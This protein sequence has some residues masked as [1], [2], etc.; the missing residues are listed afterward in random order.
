MK[1]IEQ[2]VAELDFFK[3][4][5]PEQ[6]ATV[7]G[8]GR[9]RAF[10]PGEYVLREGEEESHFY[11]IRNGSVTIEVFSPQQ[12]AL[13]VE[14][15][16][17]GDP[18]GWSWLFP[19]HHARFDARAIDVV[20]TIEFDGVCLRGK[21]DADHELGYTLLKLFGSVIAQRLHNTRM[22]LLDVYAPVAGS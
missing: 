19:P 7:A 11:V 21:C 5:A 2:L 10:R 20:T 9:T 17:A 1:D 4:L 12:G 13:T 3:A 22:R 8:C 15:V 14:T 16:H 6:V 18:L